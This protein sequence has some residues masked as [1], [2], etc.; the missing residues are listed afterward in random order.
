M[1]CEHAIYCNVLWDYNRGKSSEH[2][3]GRHY[4]VQFSQE[5]NCPRGLQCR[6]VVERDVFSLPNSLTPNTSEVGDGIGM[7]TIR[8]PSFGTASESEVDTA[9]RRQS[10]NHQSQL[11][12]AETITEMCATQTVVKVIFLTISREAFPPSLQQEL[13]LSSSADMPTTIKLM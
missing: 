3:S 13:E 2:V 10:V 12:F 1:K 11:P 7:N 4:L 6:E 8:I 5:L 9:Q